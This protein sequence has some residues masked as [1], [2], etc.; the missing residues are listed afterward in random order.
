MIVGLDR[1]SGGSVTVNGKRHANQRA[2]LPAVGGLT[3]LAPEGVAWVRLLARRPAA[4][5]RTPDFA[6]L[7]PIATVALLKH[8][9]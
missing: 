3:R 6:R 9:M 7:L 5:G 2:P 1:P 4:E 8:D